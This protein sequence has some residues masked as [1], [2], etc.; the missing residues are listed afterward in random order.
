KHR[1]MESRMGQAVKKGRKAAPPEP[2][3]LSMKKKE[4]EGFGS[5]L[6]A[7]GAQGG[8]EAGSGG[9]GLKN[10]GMLELRVKKGFPQTV[11]AGKGA[12]AELEGKN[13]TEE[14]VVAELVA[15]ATDAK[16]APLACNSSP[17]VRTFPPNGKIEFSLSFAASEGAKRGIAAVVARL[18]EKA[19]YIDRAA[20]TSKEIRLTFRIVDA[21]AGGKRP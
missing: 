13:N 7:K 2:V 3:Y 12:V 15:S 9:I 18:E 8:E 4:N 6:E 20:K 17:R 11:A 5:G 16:G 10:E 19:E 14:R 1:E 21:E